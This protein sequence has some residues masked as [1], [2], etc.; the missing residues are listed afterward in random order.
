MNRNSIVVR[1]A[2]LVGLA[3]PLTMALSNAAQA[4][5]GAC[6]RVKACAPVQV[7]TPLPAP[8][9]P[10]V[11]NPPPKACEPVKGHLSQVIGHGQ[12]VHALGA[13]IRTVAYAVKY[14]GAE[15]EYAVPQ[16]TASA[17]PAP[18][19]AP[20]PNPPKPPVPEKT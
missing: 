15:T 4:G 11:V 14:R 6:E 19:S 8:C 12:V 2:L 1:V 17:S 3:I 20:A 7:V 18:A 16:P 13:R 10:A 5:I 9:A